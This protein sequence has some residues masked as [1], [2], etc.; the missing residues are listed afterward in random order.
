MSKCEIAM[1]VL[2]LASVI[3]LFIAQVVNMHTRDQIRDHNNLI[4]IMD[5]DA[6]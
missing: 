4:D 5:S 1:T 6:P 2:A 3:M